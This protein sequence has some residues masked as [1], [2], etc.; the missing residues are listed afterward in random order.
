MTIKETLP[1]GDQSA[2]RHLNTRRVLQTLYDGPPLT[3]SGVARAT[4]LSRPTVQGILTALVDTGLLKPD[5]HD[6]VRTGGRPAQ[7]Y[8]F[9]VDAGYLAGVDIGAHAVSVRVANLNGTPFAGARRAVEAAT[10]A[11]ERI[12]AAAQL[13]RQTLP[14]D[15]GRLWA[16][17]V[18]TPGIVDAAGV[19]RLSVALPGWTGIRLPE[20][21]GERFGCP[22]TAM[23]DTN[24]A[25]LAEHRVGAAQDSS[26][27]LYVHV[28]HRLGVGLLVGG[29][30]FTG[31]TGGAG[32]IGRHPVLGWEQAPARLLADAGLAATVDE[33]ASEWVFTRARRGDEGAVKAVDAF[34]RT[35]ADGIGAMVL[36]VAPQMIVIGGGVAR[37]GTVVL[38]PIRRHLAEVCY[39][40]PPLAVSALGEDAVNIGA[41]EAARD[42]VREQLFSAMPEE[43]GHS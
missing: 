15:R 8:R 10:G 33:N 17:G 41:V 39:E 3:T 7:R 5:G 35:L 25:A 19:V 11:A 31:G 9:N 23:K 22:V 28:G 30:P 36:A 14:A 2:L 13:L 21:I 43:S 20:E 1:G 37:A 38:D 16:I 34:A 26:D 40:V 32:E 18:G 24:L 27:V 42:H 12:E 29:R 6:I 4:G